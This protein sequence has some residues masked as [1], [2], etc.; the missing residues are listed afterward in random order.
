M[1]TPNPEQQGAPKP[2]PAAP[3]KRTL[4]DM[5]DGAYLIAHR[6]RAKLKRG[7]SADVMTT[8]TAD[9]IDLLVG[10]S[11]TLRLMHLYGADQFVR[12]K[13]NKKG[14]RR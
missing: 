11:E 2:A 4:S 10:V 13:I 8:L 5:S 3:R 14:G 9:E 1:T 12:D 6:A 7:G